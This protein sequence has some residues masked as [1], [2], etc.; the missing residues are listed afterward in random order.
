MPLGPSN[1]RQARDLSQCLK[2]SAGGPCL[3]STSL[4]HSLTFGGRISDTCS[5]QRNWGALTL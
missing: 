4:D 1:A 3:H 5:S 2:R